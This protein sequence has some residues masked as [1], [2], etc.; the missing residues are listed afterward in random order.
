M[1]ISDI[2]LG[3][4]PR[5]FEVEVGTSCSDLKKQRIADKEVEREKHNQVYKSRI[6]ELLAEIKDDC[7]TSEIMCSPTTYWIRFT[8]LTVSTLWIQTLLTIILV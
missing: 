2:D 8:C 3:S 5:E 7:Q 1:G 4:G 6:E